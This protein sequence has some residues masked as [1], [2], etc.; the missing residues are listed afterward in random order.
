M[1][2]IARARLAML[3]SDAVIKRANKILNMSRISTVN[4]SCNIAA[5]TIA[6]VS[7]SNA[8]TWKIINGYNNKYILIPRL[9]TLDETL[10]TY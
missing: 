5:K 1:A 4:I 7:P 3:R 8:K 2:T 9:T 10:K 6:A